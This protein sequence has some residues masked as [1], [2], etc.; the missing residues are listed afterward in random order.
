MTIE[1]EKLKA[2]VE[3]PVGGGHWIYIGGDGT[4]PNKYAP[5]LTTAGPVL[6]AK[7][8]IIP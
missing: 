3:V 2:T 4:E 1:Q 7:G 8:R 6:N 5:L